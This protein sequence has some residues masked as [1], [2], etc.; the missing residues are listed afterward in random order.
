ML[1]DE[2]P[3]LKVPTECSSHPTLCVTVAAY[4]LS[5]TG[6]PPER[7]FFEHVWFFCYYKRTSQNPQKAKFTS[8][9]MHSPGSIRQ[10]FLCR[11]SKVHSPTYI[12]HPEYR[13][14]LGPLIG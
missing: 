9:I 11:V 14:V 4:S 3:L 10:E 6:A 7:T 12:R 2:Y 13:Q 1:V 5:S 8:R